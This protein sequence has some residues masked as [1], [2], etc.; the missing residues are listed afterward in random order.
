MSSVPVPYDV[1]SDHADGF[2]FRK[3]D[4]LLDSLRVCDMAMQPV[5]LNRTR[6]LIRQSDPQIYNIL[7][8]QNG[9]VART[10][11][12]NEVTYSP[13][14][15]H[16][17]D[18]SQPCESRAHSTQGMIRCIGVVIPKKLLP[19]PG[20]GTERLLGRRLQGQEGV[21]G[22][23]AGFLTQLTTNPRS[24]LPSD[25]LR[26]SSVLLDLTSALIAHALEADDILVPESRQ[27]GLVLRIRNFVQQNLHDPRLTP[28][29]IATAHHISTSY[30]HRLFQRDGTQVA[31]WIRE[32][33]LERARRDLTD[34]ALAVVPIA[35]IAARWGF[36][37]AA[38]FSRAF[39]AAYGTTPRDHRHRALDPRHEQDPVYP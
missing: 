6:Q 14:D 11:R 31:A 16:I 29:A 26:L 37:H 21:G 35:E 33:R 2:R 19:L 24:Y 17:F 4:L 1:S 7:L 34:P 9:T 39:R 28:G 36:I 18:P 38:A 32:R 23:L 22:L 10:W 15:L 20:S 30:L 5:V 27:R 12:R 25:G 3:R 13:H 8:L